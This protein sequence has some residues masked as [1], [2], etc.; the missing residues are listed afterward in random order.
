MREIVFDT[1]TTGLYPNQGHRLVEVGCIELVNRQTTG[2]TFH[3]YVNPEREVPRE[4]FAIHGLSYDFLKD[5]PRFYTIADDFLA[6]IGNDPLIAHNAMFDLSFINAELSRAY[7]V[8][9]PYN[10]D[11]RHAVH[12]APE[13]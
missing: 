11:H 8:Y 13:A 1:E 2:R 12:G 5:H 9:H 3:T 7:K 10:P 6:F 4:A